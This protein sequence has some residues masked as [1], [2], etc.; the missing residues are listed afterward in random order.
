MLRLAL[1]DQHF[2]LPARSV[3]VEHFLEELL[4]LVK[5]FNR[6]DRSDGLPEGTV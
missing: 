3:H 5:I 6:A 4:G 2:L 1:C